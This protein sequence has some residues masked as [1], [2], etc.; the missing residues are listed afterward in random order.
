M[1]GVCQ[2]PKLV[3]Q[4]PLALDLPA[5]N[6]SALPREAKKWTRITCRRNHT[7][8]RLPKVLSLPSYL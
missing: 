6:A 2:A 4:P 5:C 8:A 7:S 1:L 3:S